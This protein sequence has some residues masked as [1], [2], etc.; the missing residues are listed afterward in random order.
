MDLVLDRK[1][2]ILPVEVKYRNKPEKP[3][4]IAA[5]SKTF[6]GKGIPSSIVITKDSLD[7]DGETLYVPFWLVR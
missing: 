7:S 1:T 6:A 3:V 4:S 5:F 2:D